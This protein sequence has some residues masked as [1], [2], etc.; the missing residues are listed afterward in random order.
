MDL[1]LHAIHLTHLN[2][3]AFK[4]SLKNPRSRPDQANAETKKV[5]KVEKPVVSAYSG[6]SSGGLG[7]FKPPRAT[8][9]SKKLEIA[10]AYGLETLPG[11]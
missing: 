2:A 6:N 7:K 5:R 1:L 11:Q 9:A 8:L 10:R 3:D 4:T